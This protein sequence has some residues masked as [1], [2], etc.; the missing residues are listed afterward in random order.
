MSNHSK[1]HWDWAHSPLGSRHL[2]AKLVV[3]SQSADSLRRSFQEH[4]SSHSTVR[5]QR[6]WREGER[7]RQQRRAR[8]SSRICARKVGAKN[9]HRI[10]RADRRNAWPGSH[11][12]S[13]RGE[14]DP[15]ERCALRRVLQEILEFVFSHDRPIRC[16][17][18]QRDAQL[19][20][21]L[22]DGFPLENACAQ[23]ECRPLPIDPIPPLATHGCLLSANL[24]QSHVQRPSK[25]SQ[26]LPS[27][28][29]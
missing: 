28:N 4:H 25:T 1:Q 17:I 3:D 2:Q 26:H 6:R 13:R 22:K 27:L 5:A 29:Y 16:K 23:R 19:A 10:P 21:C 24:G 14:C 20:T 9:R 12:T 18:G 15:A 8:S 11:S 7:L